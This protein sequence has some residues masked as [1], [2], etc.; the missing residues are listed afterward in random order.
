M[1][2]KR[3]E[4]TSTTVIETTP[5]VAPT[6]PPWLAEALA[7]LRALRVNGMQTALSERLRVERGR[8]GIYVATDFV[9][10]LLAYAVSDAPHLKAFVRSLAPVTATL[11]ALWDRERLPSSSALSRV[12]GAT[13]PWAT[14]LSPVESLGGRCPLRTPEVPFPIPAGVST[15]R[16]RL[17]AA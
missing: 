1:A 11:A 15:S 2:Q 16:R 10:L 4:G 6:A 5:E 7:V 9:L 12:R 3:S 13:S 14:S 8:A 17:A